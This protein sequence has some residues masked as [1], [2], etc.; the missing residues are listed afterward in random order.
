M[1]EYAKGIRIL[2]CV[3][4]LWGM[5][6]DRAGD[7]FLRKSCGGTFNKGKL[8]NVSLDVVAMEEGSEGRGVPAPE[9]ALRIGKLD[10]N[11]FRCYSKGLLYEAT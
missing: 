1:E 10:V 11:P 3:I 8:Y 9:V 5:V 4:Y 7:N 2:I 6:Q